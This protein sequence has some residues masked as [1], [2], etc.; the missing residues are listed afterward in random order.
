[1]SDSRAGRFRQRRPLYQACRRQPATAVLASNLSRVIAIG[2]LTSAESKR[3]VWRSFLRHAKRLPKSDRVA[4]TRQVTNCR[5][6][7]PCE[8]AAS[9]ALS[10][11]MSAVGHVSIL[12]HDIL[13]IK[14]QSRIR[15]SPSPHIRA[16]KPF[17]SNLRSRW[18][19]G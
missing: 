4:G 12:R 16:C 6:F 13:E 11:V 1:L 18:F 17:K 7:E 9:T 14:Q 15:G 2:L 3:A 5:G 8:I 19:G 10:E